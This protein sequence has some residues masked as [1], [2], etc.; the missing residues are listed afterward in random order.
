MVGAG[1]TLIGLT[2]LLVTYT[3]VK[4]TRVHVARGRVQI[5][6]GILTRQ[7][8]NIELWRVDGVELKRS[9]VNRLTGDGTLLLTVHTPHR[10]YAVTGVAT[11]PRLEGMYQALLNLVF[12]LRSNPNIKGIIQ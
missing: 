10:V 7:K 2:I 1:L 6:T 8:T 4:T 9:W 11:G 12:L 3:W 5:E